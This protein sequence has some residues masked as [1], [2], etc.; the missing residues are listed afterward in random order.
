[1]I[2]LLQ[3]LF[4]PLVPVQID[5]RLTDIN[6]KTGLI[7]TSEIDDNFM[8]NDIEGYDGSLFSMNNPNILSLVKGNNNKR[9]ERYL[10]E[11]T[12]NEITMDYSVPSAR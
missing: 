3:L 7:Q 12:L 6:L 9:K 11:S 8:D 10:D 1:M 5:E 4:L 2:Q